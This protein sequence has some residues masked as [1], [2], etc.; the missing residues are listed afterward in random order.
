MAR[1]IWTQ[2]GVPF[3]YERI[4][5]SMWRAMGWARDEKPNTVINSMKKSKGGEVPDGGA[6]DRQ[7]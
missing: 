2:M 6:P 4:A 5:E 7:K 1:K 3:L